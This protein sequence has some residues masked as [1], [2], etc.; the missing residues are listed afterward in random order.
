MVFYKMYIQVKSISCFIDK[1][2]AGL[3]TRIS[4]FS[5]YSQYS[6]PWLVFVPLVEP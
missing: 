4:I 5:P 6:L 2:E 1:S 3:M